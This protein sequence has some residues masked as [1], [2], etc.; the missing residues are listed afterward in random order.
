MLAALAPPDGDLLLGVGLAAAGAALA[1]WPVF[2]VLLRAFNVP[3][4]RDAV[5]ANVAGHRPEVPDL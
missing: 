4:R 2:P 1:A 5:G 3:L